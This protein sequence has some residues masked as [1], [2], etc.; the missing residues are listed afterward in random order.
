MAVLACGNPGQGI[1]KEIYLPWVLGSTQD[2]LG[3]VPC[4]IRHQM[5]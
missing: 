1:T 3:T 2:V 5:S 4:D